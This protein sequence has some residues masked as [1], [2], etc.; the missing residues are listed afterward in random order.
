MAEG[1][2]VYVKCSSCQYEGWIRLA[3]GIVVNNAICPQCRN[4][5]LVLYYFISPIAGG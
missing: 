2:E 5:T 1:N 3:D 4:R